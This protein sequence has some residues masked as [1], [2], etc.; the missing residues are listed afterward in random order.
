[1]MNWLNS[2]PRRIFLVDGLGAL[3]SAL[4]LFF[5]LRPFHVEV[6]MPREVLSG[7]SA[8]AVVLF[9]YSM[10][11]FLFLKGNVTRF[12]RIIAFANLMYCFATLLLVGLYFGEL[13]LLGVAYFIGEVFLIGALVF[14]EMRL[15]AGSRNVV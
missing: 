1:M 10:S 8:G 2:N 13:S 9:V 11:C 4:L 15:A 12:L 5:L 6:G 3:T 7:L 14:I